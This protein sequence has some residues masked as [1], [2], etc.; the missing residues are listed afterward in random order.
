MTKLELVNAVAEAAGLSKVAAKKA[1]DAA[2][3][4]VAASLKKGEAVVLPGFGS[5]KVAVRAE[6]KGIN[7]RTKQAIVIPAAKV[8]KFKPGKDLK[9]L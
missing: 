1:V 4:A 5:F 6:R 7:L 8:A 2:F 3:G 9:A